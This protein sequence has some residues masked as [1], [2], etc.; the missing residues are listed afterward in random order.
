MCKLSISIL[1]EPRENAS[2]LASDF[3]SCPLDKK[4]ARRLQRFISEFVK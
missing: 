3:S 2:L 1:L 4:L